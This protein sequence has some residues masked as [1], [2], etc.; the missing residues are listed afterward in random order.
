MSQDVLNIGLQDNIHLLYNTEKQTFRMK[1]A[2]LRFTSEPWDI[3][4]QNAFKEA[5]QDNKYFNQIDEIFDY[6]EKD[7]FYDII[8]L[9]GVRLIP[10]YN[11]DGNRIKN[12]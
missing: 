8:I 7:K 10:K 6:P 11:L 9:C 1:I 3:V 2:L 12:Q 4:I 5:L